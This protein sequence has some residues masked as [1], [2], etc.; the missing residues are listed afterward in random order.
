MQQLIEAD[1]LV[2]AKGYFSYYAALISDGIKIYEPGDWAPGLP[3]DNWIPCLSDGSFDCVAFERQLSLL[4]QAKA[5]V[6]TSPVG[7]FHPLPPAG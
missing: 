5:V 7:L 6:A 1:I 3:D 4:L 2:M